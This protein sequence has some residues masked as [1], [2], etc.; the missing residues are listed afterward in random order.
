M[1]LLSFNVT[2]FQSYSSLSYDFTAD[3]PTLITGPTGS[4]K[5]T[6]MDAPCWI[7]FGKTSKESA[8]D[9]V[10]SWFSTSLPT[11]GQLNLKLNNGDEVEVIRVRGKS[12]SQND[13][14][15]TVFKETMRDRT[16][17][18]DQEIIRGKDLN[19]TQSKL[20]LLLKMNY[21][22]YTSAVYLHQFSKSDSFFIAK[23]QDRK[24]IIESIQ[25]LSEAMAFDERLKVAKKKNKEALKG[26][27]NAKLAFTSKLGTLNQ[28]LRDTKS[29]S[30]SFD[31]EL[32]TKKTST[33]N[34]HN[35]FEKDKQDKVYKTLDKVEQI[36]KLIQDPT[37]FLTKLTNVKDQILKAQGVD[38]EVTA[39]VTQTSSIK[40]EISLIQIELDRVSQL[41]PTC[42]TCKGDTHN[43]NLVEWAEAS[44][45]KIAELEVS[46]AIAQEELKI[47]TLVKQQVEALHNSH[48]KLTKEQ[49]E[50]E[51]YKQTY[52]ALKSQL[53]VLR[54][55]QSPYGKMLESLNIQVNPHTSTIKDTEDKVV[56]VEADL[57]KVNAKIHSI[58]SE[59][60]D[61]EWLTNASLTTRG[62]MLTSTIKT[63]EVDT[64][65]I[66]TE[67]FDSYI[68]VAFSIEGGD[69]IDTQIQNN[70]Y[71][72]PFRQLSGGERCMLK[73]AFNISYLK[74]V[75][76]NLNLRVS[77][78]ML[79]E[80]FSGLDPSLK[81]KAYA[82]IEH[83]SMQY[84]NVL[85]I[86]HSDEL[87]EMFPF[88]R[89]ITKE[90]STS[91]LDE[92]S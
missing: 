16:I 48:I 12:P 29:R 2:N 49:G 90:G 58:V 60:S 63:L 42:P 61:L 13:L 47:K 31:H 83:L 1:K 67:F 78:I 28:I 85:V 18:Y 68:Q 30:D 34:A 43:P 33:T 41:D 55:E 19:D 64:N 4:G 72:C 56:E 7:L 27:E 91:R 88:I 89:T 65:Q 10:R 35:S 15:F 92:Q 79:D 32:Q 36:S 22:T 75:Q 51:S 66:L 87:K 50:N 6:L 71:E 39:L 3:S 21:K 37:V 59:A 77:F 54:S 70:G 9:D 69:K 14:F 5:S 80:A 17:T 24:E 86:E 84:D 62:N 8:V 57:V 45:S 40:K 82:F 52:Q 73:L 76:N 23:H 81:V 20:E 26:E 38:K 11:S 44:F 25:D 74:A 53:E 46:L